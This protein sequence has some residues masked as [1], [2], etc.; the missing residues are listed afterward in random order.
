MPF[1]T[2]LSGIRAASTDLSVTGNN[3]AN[4]STT[5]FKASRAE[6]SDV[7]A[8][9]VLGA[10]TNA[11][12]AG[13]QVEGITQRF[14]QGNVSFTQ[15][16]LDLAINGNGFFVTSRDGEILY[17]RAG[18]FGLDDEG[19]VTSTAGARLQGFPA[20][21]SGNTDGIAADIRIETRNLDPRRTTGVESVLNL[22]AT[23]PV[24]QSVG[25]ELVTS[26]NEIGVTQGGRQVAT[27]TTYT[28]TDLTLPLPYN[29]STP[30]TFDI[31]LSGSSGNDGTVSVSV[32]VA[33]GVPNPIST[34]NDLRTLAS[35]ISSKI[36]SPTAPQTA[37]DVFARAEQNV[38]AGTVNLQFIA[39]QEGESSSITVTDTSA[40][41]ANLGVGGA[42]AVLSQGIAEVSNG[43]SAQSIDIID[44]DGNAVTYTSRANATAAS[45]AAELNAIQ[46]VSATAQTNLTLSNYNS[47]GQNMVVTLNNISLSGDSLDALAAEI[48]SLTNTTLPGITATVNGTILELSSAVGDDLVI[49]IASPDD[50][51]SLTVQG[52]TGAPSQ[53]LEVDAANDGLSDP[54]FFDAGLNSLAVGGEISIV[55]E[56]GY[57][58]ENPVPNIG[59]FQPL[60]DSEFTE[61][62]INDF[63]PVDQSTYNSATSM[64]IYDSLGNPHV[65]TQ[66]FVKQNYDSSDPTSVPNQWQV[67]VQ[68]DGVNVGDPD[69]SLPPPQNT[70]PT[71]ASYT[72]QF[73]EDGSFNRDASDDIL[74]S[75]WTP[76][77][78]NGN[79]NGAEGPLNVL[80]G[81]STVIPDPPTSSNF[82]IDYTGTT[83]FGSDFSVNDI[84]QNG[85]STGRLSGLNVDSNGVIFA[86]F[87]NGESLVLGQVALADFTNQ[88]GLQPVGSSMWA[89]NFESGPPIIGR[90][91]TAALG[92]IQSGALEESN[93]DLSEQLV[94]LIIAQRNFQASA[95]TIATADT[96]TQTI[97]NLR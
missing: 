94:N 16:E 24:L 51:D 37:I 33:D 70:V 32:G 28:G 7:Y 97:I 18:A 56:E 43:Y 8:I 87:T 80:A 42:G 58:L 25:R 60:N 95:K 64:T 79:P 26:G 66:Y 30:L 55:L 89:E 88:Q 4:A 77:D 36:A 17:T 67:Y 72:L 82:V 53:T 69:T 57:N 50:G 73:N 84:D 29:F 59:L 31:A 20:D 74:I 47:P 39:L 12:G 21:E 61:I 1:D 86:R 91:G 10:G 83:Q 6:F 68:I 54:S 90:P 93:V 27:T 45:T 13:V 92:A 65:L 11:A 44:P 34:F 81:G 40:S 85:F 9:S 19:F 76:L 5:G 14:T 78:E 3:I 38:A 22:D 23:E 96:V 41:D 71:Q 52:N 35:V 2:A 49:S 75:N 46:G 48:N 15:S 63:N 62:V